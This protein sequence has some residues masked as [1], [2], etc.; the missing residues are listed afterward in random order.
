MIGRKLSEIDMKWCIQNIN[1]EQEIHDLSI[2]PGYTGA[3]VVFW[4][5]NIS[6]GYQELSADCFPI[7]ATV[8]SGII[9]KTVGSTIN[10]Y[11]EKDLIPPPI[12]VKRIGQKIEQK[13]NL[14]TIKKLES[15]LAD[16]DQLCR[17]T[18]PLD[19][20]ESVSVV[21]CTRN[22]PRQLDEC[23]QSLQHLVN[24]PAEV[25]VVD[26][27]P[28]SNATQEVVQRY[29][30]VHYILEPRPGLSIARNT[31]IHRATGNIIAFT[32]DDVKVHP[33]WMERIRHGFQNP[34]VMV[35]TGLMLPAELETASQIAFHEGAYGFEWPCRPILYDFRYFEERK[36][37]S[38]PVWQIGAGANMALRRQV[39]D[40]VGGFNEL[41]G[42]GASGCSE[43]SEFWYR[44]LAAGWACRYEPSAVIY[45]YHRGD[46]AS[47]KKQQYAY[48]RGHVAALLIQANQHHHWGNLFRLFVALPIHYIR[49]ALKGISNRFQGNYRTVFV[50]IIGCFAGILFFIRHYSAAIKRQPTQL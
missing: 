49:L 21:I 25:L 38:T 15:P 36:R 41:L 8:L 44:V 13:Y 23:L 5:K 47:L 3:F 9:A 4:W 22:R 40:A 43:D 35:V 20:Q 14:E 31:G 16:L 17:L 1:L 27:A 32:D 45:H 37:F 48:M 12:Q 26:N 29:P 42:A 7:S 39:V 11:L 10:H 24:Y 34:N 18:D 19:T 30:E 2:Q 50:E 28:T 6:L 46:L 33:H